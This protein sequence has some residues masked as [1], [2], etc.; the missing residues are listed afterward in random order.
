MQQKQII[1]LH[2]Q[3]YSYR[4]IAKELGIHRN[5]VKDY[6][7]RYNQ[8]DL[9]LK[10]AL[11]VQTDLN[12]LLPTESPVKEPDQRYKDLKQLLEDNNKLRRRPG[13]TMDNLY[14]DYIVLSTGSHYCIFSPS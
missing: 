8:S 2:D 11:D 3:G 7:K 14:K 4:R 10:E 5:T 6:I 13:F 12:T 9:S 1:R